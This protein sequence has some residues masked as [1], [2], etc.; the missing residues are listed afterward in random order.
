M[1]ADQTKLRQALFNL[2]S[3]ATKFSEDGE[4]ILR[5]ERV[6]DTI[7]F[8][9]HDT[10]IGMTPEQLG[11]LFQAFSQA[12][13]STTRKFGGTGL[14]LTISRQF[15]RMMGGD[16]TVESVIG[17]GSTF[18][19][20]LPAVVVEGEEKPAP[21]T[22]RGAPGI[23]SNAPVVLVI[24]DDPHM[25]DLT[26]R[27]LG[28]EGYRVECAANGEQGIAMAKELRPAVITLDVMM[29]GLDGWAV[30]T[31]LKADALT[32]DIPVIMMT[33][34][35]EERVGFSLG[36]SDYFTKPVDWNKL[37]A[38][39]AKH[40]DS[41]GEGVLIVEDDS[42]T[43]EL[44][45]RTL[46]KDGWKVREAANGRIGLEQVQAAI[47]SVVLLD[48]MMPELDGFGFMEG[49]R[50][51]PGCKHVPVI[52]IT[53]KDLTA[54]DRARLNGE[55][56]RILQKASFSPESLVAE[57]RELVSHQTEFII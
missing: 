52:V 48:L 8:Q 15:C 45:V 13:A 10:G 17:V 46:E 5:A 35:D 32:A 50:Q 43:R 20:T 11:K 27:S 25:R 26:T 40:R 24:D 49:L 9:V 47:P 54:D 55:V 18:T 3:N 31:A 42:N 7:R 1:H 57:I 56:S 12:D 37:A 36:A 14:G 22:S 53:A 44:L 19:A 38:S 33:M 28:K 30:L 16:L 23:K 29:P 51:T 39:I 41:T 34:V 2:L 4:V 6:G 21:E